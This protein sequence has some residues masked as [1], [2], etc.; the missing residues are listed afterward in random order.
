MEKKIPLLAVVG[1]TASGKTALAVELAKRQNGEVVS[2]DSMQI[3]KQMDIGTAKPTREEMDGIPHHLLDFLDGSETF[4][5]AQYVEMAR[6][7]IRDIHQRG[8]LPILAGGTGLYV[9]SLL[10]HIQF[11]EEKTDS[12]LRAHLNQRMQQEGAEVL[13]EEL[14]RIDPQTA[15]KLHPN[16]QKRIVRALEIYQTTGI[17]MSEQMRRSRA[18]PSPYQACVIGLDYR[19]REVLY[20]RINQRVD[21]MIERGLPEEAKRIL[22]SPLGST[23]MGAIGYKELAPWVRGE[24][25]LDEAAETLKRSTRRY[26]KRQLTWFRREEGI[27]WIHM[28]ECKN[29]EDI[30]QNS[31]R[32]MEI[33][34][35]LC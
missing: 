11:S 14:R 23:A 9:S 4:S 10:H 31:L 25:S 20:R 32:C 19:D 3:Y 17:T 16:N 8:K 1:P 5:V 12:A 26:A 6:A 2:A 34:G 27:H 30:V 33:D 18:Q 28:D 15:E 24:C 13:L 21:R 22:L 29:F 35:I 7:C